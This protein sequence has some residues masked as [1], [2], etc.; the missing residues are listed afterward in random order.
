M[1]DKQPAPQLSKPWRPAPV[2]AHVREQLREAAKANVLDRLQRFCRGPGK[3]LTP[4]ERSDIAGWVDSL[5]PAQVIELH[6]LLEC[7]G[8]L[9]T[10]Y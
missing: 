6:Q 1:A 4:T 7:A 3:D 8:Y 9:A 2:I 10:S 5:Q